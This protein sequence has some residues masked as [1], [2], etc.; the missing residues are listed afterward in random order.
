MH[1]IAFAQMVVIVAIHFTHMHSFLFFESCTCILHVLSFT[2]FFTHLTMNLDFSCFQSPIE[3]TRLPWPR[4][5]LASTTHFWKQRLCLPSINFTSLAQHWPPGLHCAIL[6]GSVLLALETVQCSLLV[7]C[8]CWLKLC[9]TQ[10]QSS[11][12]QD[13]LCIAQFQNSF[14]LPTNQTMPWVV[15]V[16][17]LPTSQWKLCN[18]HD[19]SH[20]YVA[21]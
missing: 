4:L 21:S 3:W 10:F 13:G 16:V 14:S 8:H 15:L 1:D 2:L 20:R 9:I 7:A 19:Q 18:L 17:S 11:A 5:C 6:W 12:G